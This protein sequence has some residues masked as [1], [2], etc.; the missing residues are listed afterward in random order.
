M[1]EPEAQSSMVAIPIESE[2]SWQDPEPTDLRAS[3]NYAPVLHPTDW[4]DSWGI[5]D[6]FADPVE[7]GI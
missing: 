2:A 7:R 4:S 6:P 1:M 3:G 5:T